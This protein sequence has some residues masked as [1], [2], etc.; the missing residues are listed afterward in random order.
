MR[1]F[2]TI[3]TEEDFGE[4][5]RHRRQRKGRGGSSWKGGG[6]VSEKRKASASGA[7]RG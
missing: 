1:I 6:K 5:I 4:E 7:G 3:L 2:R